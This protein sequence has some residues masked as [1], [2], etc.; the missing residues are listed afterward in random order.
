MKYDKIDEIEKRLRASRLYRDFGFFVAILCIAS[1]FY[2]LLDAKDN[3]SSILTSTTDNLATATS[4][5]QELRE[6]S[7]SI[8]TEIRRTLAD[9]QQT[10]HQILTVEAIS[11]DDSG[12]LFNLSN[13]QLASFSACLDE[14]GSVDSI[15]SA[16]VLRPSGAC[17][18]EIRTGVPAGSLVAAA[19]YDSNARSMEILSQGLENQIAFIDQHVEEIR[20]DTPI[21]RQAD[22]D[23]IS[24]IRSTF[25]FVLIPSF[26]SA[27]ILLISTIATMHF[28]SR[29]D[30]QSRRMEVLMRQQLEQERSR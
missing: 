1:L 10:T 29:T 13:G 12:P 20:G 14:L 4:N 26:A 17:A 7:L 25:S 30:S 6:K 28:A 18:R 2:L 5:Y 11:Q 21:D 8:A 3:Y 15:A 27:I 16:A 22:E 9:L 24:E 23:D 19:A